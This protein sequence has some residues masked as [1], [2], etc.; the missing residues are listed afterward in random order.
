MNFIPTRIKRIEDAGFGIT[1]LHYCK[2]YWWFS[3]VLIML[4]ERGY[5]SIISH[6]PQPFLCDVCKG[7]CKRGR[8][9]NGMNDCGDLS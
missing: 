7:R 8:D 2:V 1:K 3:P 5:P 6:T 4:L 9:G